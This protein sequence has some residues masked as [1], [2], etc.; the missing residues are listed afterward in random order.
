MDGEGWVVT[1]GHV[2]QPA[3][4]TPRWLVNQQAQRA[5][6]TACL[7]KAL[8]RARIVP[9]E[10][11]EADDAVKRKL[12]DKVLPTT[13]VNLTPQVVVI[14]SNGTRI[15]AEVKK[16]SPPVS[17]EPG[18]MSGRDLALLKISG[19]A[20][21]VL[22]LTDAKVAQIGDPI[23]ILGFPGVVSTHEL[24][25]KS[26]SREASVTNGAVS[27]FQEDVSGAPM[28][29]TDASASWGNSGGPA[30]GRP[31]RDG[32]G[33]HLRVAGARS[34]GRHRPGLQ[35]HH[36][37]AGGA[38]LRLRAPPVKLGEMGHV[39]PGVVCRAPRLLHRRLEGRRASASRRPIAS[40]RTCPTSSACWPR[41]ARR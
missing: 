27:G 38:R 5:V 31:R 34:R 41:R 33:A 37:G 11:P 40:C 14:I 15:K 10:K 9:G 25:N 36:P 8:E 6:V 32:R 2:V 3:H 21:P 16:Y 28:I 19:D 29:Q 23:H 26:A 4:E 17:T 12:L 1:N 30:V 35:L 39:R 24:L 20:Y 18:A 22:P 7:P 13:K